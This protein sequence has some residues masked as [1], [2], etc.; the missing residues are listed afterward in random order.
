MPLT[1]SRL[2]VSA[3]LLLAATVFLQSFSFLSLKISTL[4]FGLWS[5]AFLLAAFLFM[6]LRA[7]F[8]QK[9]L[10]L[11]DLSLVYPFTSLVQVL[12]LVYAVALFKETVSPNH[13]VGL[14]LM[15]G[16]TFVMSRE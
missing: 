6:G 12:I 15:L 7:V 13:I 10:H 8:W 11:A 1:G 4:N 5:L 16:G 2:S 3:R 14:L 9:L